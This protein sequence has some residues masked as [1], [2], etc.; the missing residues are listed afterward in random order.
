MITHC[1]I[2]EVEIGSG[3]LQGENGARNEL[4]GGDLINHSGN[5][6]CLTS[7]QESLALPCTM[8]WLSAVT[9]FLSA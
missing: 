2:T 1:Y 5:I 9:S 7:S 3:G 6:L 4:S 8:W